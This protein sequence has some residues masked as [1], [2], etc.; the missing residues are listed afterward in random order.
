MPF[1][2]TSAGVN[3]H[4]EDYGQGRPIV[5]IHG[6][7]GSGLLWRFQRELAE[8]FRLIIPD[9]RGHGR[10]SGSPE[11]FTLE[12]L[13][14]DIISLFDKL[15][16]ADAVLVGWSLG[17]QAAMA[18]FPRLRRRLAGLVLV[19]GTARFTAT[20]GYPQGLP[21]D[22]VRGMG[23]RLKR[24][25][26]RT[27]GEFFRSMFAEG[28][29]SPETEGRIDREIMAEGRLT[30]PAIAQA[31]LS[32]LATADLREMLPSIDLPVLLIHGDSDTICPPVA[33]RYLAGRLPKARLLEYAGVGHAPPLSRPGEFNAHLSE[34]LK[35]TVNGRL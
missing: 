14:V 34:F 22:E 8:N 29:L 21:A 12:G 16:L 30:E 9:L 23:L 28:E 25:H 6:W 19:G 27:M 32:L 2:E 17:S 35:E 10:S 26:E 4:Y 5:L 20:E 11:S 31:G 18:T 33:A 13:V 3:I 1:L 7:A 24:G 15:N